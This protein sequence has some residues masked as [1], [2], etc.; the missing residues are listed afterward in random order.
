MGGVHEVTATLPAGIKTPFRPSSGVT[1][2]SLRTGALSLGTLGAI[3]ASA[4]DGFMVRVVTMP[5]SIPFAEFLA[6]SA[7]RGR[8]NE[9]TIAM[10]II[11]ATTVIALPLKIEA[12]PKSRVPIKMIRAKSSSKGINSGRLS[13]GTT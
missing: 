9:M 13:I 4:L 11:D 1:T 12:P 7:V 6:S 10:K 5:L 2:I 3:P 8:N